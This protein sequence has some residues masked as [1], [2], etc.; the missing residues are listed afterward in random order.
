MAVQ[1]DLDERSKILKTIIELSQDNNRPIEEAF[2][3]FSEFIN[4]PRRHPSFMENWI[5]FVEEISEED[6]EAQNGE[7]IE[8]ATTQIELDS[9]S[10]KSEHSDAD[11]V[12]EEIAE[13]PTS[14][15][16]V[17]HEKEDKEEDLEK[18]LV[19]VGINQHDVIEKEEAI[20][21]TSN[22]QKED[23]YGKSESQ[24]IKIEDQDKFMPNFDSQLQNILDEFFNTNQASFDKFEARCDNLVEKA[25]DVERQLV[26][27]KMKQHAIMEQEEFKDKEDGMR[28]PFKVKNMDLYVTSQFQPM[29]FLE[30]DLQYKEHPSNKAKEKSEIDKVID[31]ICAL[32]AMAILKRIWKQHPLFLKFMGVLTIKRK[33]TVDIFHLSYKTP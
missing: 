1:W 13:T 29:K 32:F 3:L 19:E 15:E 8:S 5:E 30:Q 6:F 17:H 21:E 33:K 9:R 12:V 18:L 23:I 10:N 31:M 20:R 27:I 25:Y 2:E 16:E 11:K 22:M 26:E 4:R 24:P 14:E 28:E 7:S